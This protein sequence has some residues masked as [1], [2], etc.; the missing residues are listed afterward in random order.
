MNT[1]TFTPGAIA[2]AVDVIVDHAVEQAQVY[3]ISA[4]D[5]LNEGQVRL[6]GFLIML[7]LAYGSGFPHAEHCIRTGLDRLTHAAFGCDLNVTRNLTVPQNCE[8]VTGAWL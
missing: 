1:L 7:R 5:Y 3:P 4:L 8:R 6:R 2:A